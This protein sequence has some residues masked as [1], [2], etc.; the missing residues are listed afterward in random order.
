MC[1]GERS[2]LGGGRGGQ[3]AGKKDVLYAVCN[4]GLSRG[5]VILHIVHDGIASKLIPE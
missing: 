4:R 2:S 5:S 3:G 1:R